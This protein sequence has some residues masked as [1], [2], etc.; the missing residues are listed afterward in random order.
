MIEGLPLLRNTAVSKFDTGSRRSGMGKFQIH[1]KR[2]ANLRIGLYLRQKVVHD[3]NYGLHW[4]SSLLFSLLQELTALWDCGTDTILR[5]YR[6]SVT[7]V[8]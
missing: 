6:P 5:A 7:R 3:A 2:I 1:G 8:L 4:A